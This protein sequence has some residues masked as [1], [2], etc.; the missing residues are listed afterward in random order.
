MA[1]ATRIWLALCLFLGMAASAAAQSPGLMDAYNKYEAASAQGR[2]AAAERHARRAMGMGE[3]EFGPN[4]A[5][6]ALLLNNLAAT[7]YRLG[8]YP[9]AV[10][11]YKRSIAVVEKALGPNHKEIGLALNNLGETYR[12]QGKYGEADKVYR[13]SI[14]ILEKSF[15]RGHAMVGMALNNLAALR[16]LQARHGDAERLYERALAIR[17]KTLGPTHSETLLTLYNLAVLKKDLGKFQEA[18]R[19]QKQVLDAQRR[20]LGPDH[21]DVGRSLNNL[22]IIYDEQGRLTDAEGLYKQALVIREKRL[23]QTHP[24]VGVTVNNLAKLYSS[25]GRYEEAIPL[26]KRAR[27]ITEKR[28]GPGHPD[29]G[30]VLNNLAGVYSIQRRYA[31]AEPLFRRAAE[32]WAKAAGPDHPEGAKAL[33]NLALLNDRQGR[34]PEAEQL[35]KRVLASFEKSLGV[36]HPSVGTVLNNLALIYKSQNRFEDAERAHNR[37]LTVRE[38]SLGPE[39][40]DVA[41]SLN[42]LAALYNT[43]G[44]PAEALRLIRRASA[45]HRDRRTLAAGELSSASESGRRKVRHVFLRHADAAYQNSIGVKDRER[46]AAL[47]DEGFQAAQ[48]AQ[49]TSTASAVARMG[50]RF[51][52]GDDALA[53]VVRSRQDALERW[54]RLDKKLSTALGEQTKADERSEIDRLRR[55]LRALKRRIAGIDRRL[56]Q[57]FPA[58]VE[59]SSP[60]PATLVEMQK[61]LGPDEALIVY[62]TW[63][64]STLMWTLRAD[65]AAM[66]RAKIGRNELQAAVKAMR[67]ELDPAGFVSRTK[68][69]PFD[70][71][72]AFELYQKLF[73]PAEPV[74]ED[75]RHVFVVPD[76]A[77]QSLPLGVLITNKPQSAFTDFT[78]YRQAPWLARKYALTTLPSVSSLRALRSFAKASRAGRPFLGIGD[79][80][81]E[82]HPGASRGI[83]LKKIFRPQG[84]ADTKAVRTLPALP[85]TADELAAMAQVLGGDG[86]GLLLREN[87][88]ESRIRQTDMSQY[89]VVTFAT[90]GLVAGELGGVAEPGLILTPPSKGTKADD[91]VL[92]ASEVARL[93]LNADLVILS[94]CNTAAADGTPGAEGLSG[95]AKAFFYAGSRALVVSHWPVASDA[96]VRLTTHMLAETARDPRIRRAE[97]LQRSM[98]AMM[99]DAKNPHLAH[100]MFW[101]PFVVVGEGGVAGPN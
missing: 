30:T 88:T 52:A 78:G 44:R 86:A 24:D 11:Y 5:T 60:R 57:E 100:P 64:H 83:P 10:N 79:P 90:H 49:A 22:A 63:T 62:L 28:L 8:R 35:Y 82:G 36:N 68:A 95:L 7:L 55:E 26:L 93:K 87:A 23:G 67:R 34:L 65:F 54:R 98:L 70:A 13:R 81:L 40:P 41:S 51:A 29:V 33:N 32:I 58:Y 45:I 14:P 25:Q 94:A 9:E 99:S 76:A 56:T 101:A 37:A 97:A 20:T 27:E 48:L 43:R 96:T 1:G 18:G 47:T 53:G 3:K 6:F 42:N 50:A 71:T 12:L 31:E 91:G 74:L 66:W 15:G 16:H 4:H 69:P 72:R 77:L 39:H 38:A 59:L 19:L 75:V 92:T 46:R 73:E 61:L 89:R 85:E 84:V 17:K 80:L 2:Y 21:P